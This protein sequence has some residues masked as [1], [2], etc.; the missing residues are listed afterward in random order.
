MNQVQIKSKLKAISQ[1]G[2]SWA[3]VDILE[4][5]DCEIHGQCAEPTEEYALMAKEILKVMK[6]RYKEQLEGHVV[7]SKQR[8]LEDL[9]AECKMEQLNKLIDNG[10]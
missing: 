10:E 6:A 1:Q 4:M 7:A 3:L 5:I 2:F 9:I 8:D